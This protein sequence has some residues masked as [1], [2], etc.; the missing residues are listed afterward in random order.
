MEN[1]NAVP[2]TL[3]VGGM[4]CNGCVRRVTDV[5]SKGGASQ[6]KVELEKAE[7]Q[8]VATPAQF[9]TIRQQLD[10]DGWE[11]RA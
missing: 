7:A 1:E 6:V 5:I 4:T 10:A 3:G 9:E 2:Q 11:V 8:F